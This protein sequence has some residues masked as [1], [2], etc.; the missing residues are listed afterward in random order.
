MRLAESRVIN[1]AGSKFPLLCAKKHQ[2]FYFIR[3]RYHPRVVIQISPGRDPLTA[4][5]PFL[6]SFLFLHPPSPSFFSTPPLA[7]EASRH[8]LQAPLINFESSDPLSSVQLLTGK[9]RA[10]PRWMTFS[11][12]Y[13]G[14][15][16]QF[17]EK[18]KRGGNA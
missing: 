17:G 8:R 16:E 10:C 13:S 5:R 4:F 1:S 6:P 7:R 12:E 3:E 18:K 2:E 9:G 14:D 15:R 11:I